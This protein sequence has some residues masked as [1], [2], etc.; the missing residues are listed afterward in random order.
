MNVKPSNNRVA[1][2][3]LLMAAG[4]VLS[5][6]GFVMMA[7]SLASEETNLAEGSEMTLFIMLGII[8]FLF[9]ACL[10]F[11]SIRRGKKRRADEMENK[12]LQLAAQSGGS[13]TAAELAMHTNLSVQQAK[14][15]LEAFTDQK[16]AYLTLSDNG[17]YVYK[18][19]GLISREEKEA[20]ESLQNLLYK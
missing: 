18:F 17:T 1:K 15:I 9:G 10:C 4:V 11:L 7:G 2:E 6:F 13:L 16:V 5:L 3:I 19:E 8:P 14:T 20:A 12:V